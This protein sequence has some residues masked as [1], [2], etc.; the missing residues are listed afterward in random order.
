MASV[1]GHRR[2]TVLRSI[3]GT[4]VRTAKQLSF[5]LILAV[6][7]ALFVAIQNRVDRNDPKLALAPLTPDRMRFV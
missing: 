7:V 4:V 1:G 2:S 5:P 3:G 6:I